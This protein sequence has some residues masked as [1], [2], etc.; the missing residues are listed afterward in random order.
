MKLLKY[1]K[2]TGIV[3]CET[4]LH[5]GGASEKIEIGGMDNPIIRNPM[6]DFPYIPGSSIKGKMRSLLE[7]DLGLVD[8]REKIKDKNGKEI[9][10]PGYGQVH[11][12]GGFNCKKQNCPIC[13][14][15]GTSAAEESQ[16]G[17]TRLIVRDAVLT[18][19]SKRELKKLKEEKGLPYAEEKWENIINRLTASAN[20]RQMERVPAGIEFKLEMI[21]RVFDN[22]EDKGVTDEELFAIVEEGLKLL[23]QDCLGGS[24]SRGYGKIKI[25]YSVSVV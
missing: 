20:P 18:D 15:F 13:R 11:K 10:N 22:N 9:N 2:I 23:Q 16:A 25:D 7:W 14:I 24:G 3:R 12:Y 17:P 5:I 8:S 19:E 6:D 1:K 4:G 21:Y